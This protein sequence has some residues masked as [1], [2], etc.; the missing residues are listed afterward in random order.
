M[1][2]ETQK[3]DLVLPPGSYAYM[4]DV[5]KGNVKIY[6]G[7]TVINPTAQER[8]V[9]FD[10]QTGT[11]RPCQT[12]EEAMKISPIAA[13]GSYIVLRNPAKTH[14]MPGSA[15]QGDEQ[16]FG[17]TII[18]PGPAS[19]A[20]WPGQVAEVVPGH[21]LR[22]NQFL[23][24]R[25]SNEEEARRN[26]SKAVVKPASDDA[27]SSAGSTAG[28]NGAA[29]PLATAGQAELTVADLPAAVAIGPGVPRPTLAAEPPPDLSMGRQLIIRGTE[30]SFYIP[31]TGIEV[32]NL[33]R[34]R[35]NDS[36]TD[37]YVRDA[38]TL[39]TLEYAILV[40][41]T[42]KKRYEIGPQVVF[43][44]PTERF[45]ESPDDAGRPSKKLRA[46][47][48]NELQ[49]I[50]VKVIADYVDDD[51]K[52][53]RAGEE[54]FI[55][56]KVAQIYYPREEHAIVKYDGRAKHFATAIPAGEG[57]YLLNR[58]T[59]EI[60]TIEGPRMLLPDPRTEVIV[61][62]VLSDRECADWYPGN[63]D[64]L[65]YNR[66]LRELLK[67]APTTRQGT[68][69]E[70]E[71]TRSLALNS[72]Q[73]YAGTSTFAM[74]ASAMPASHVGREQNLGGE[75]FSRASTYTQP[76]TITL[77]TRFQGVPQI[78][79][80]TG[81]A[82]LV[83][84]K[85]GR[86]RVVRGP[87]TALLDYDEVLESM[88]LSTGKPKTTD[89]LV[90]VAYLRVDNNK[91]SDV[92]HAETSD[93]VQVEI[94]L[95]Y[96]VNFET[97]NDD[98][99]SADEARWFNVDNYVKFLCDHARSVL[100]GAVRKVT[101]EDF[102]EQSTDFVRDV[103]LGHG[104]ARDDG[105]I[106]PRPGMAFAQNGMRVTDVEVL[107]VG[108]KDEAIRQLL[109]RAHHDDIRAHVETYNL[110][111]NL[112][113]V[114]RREE[115]TREQELTIADTVR[116]RHQ[117]ETEQAASAL[118]LSLAKMEN[119]LRELTELRKTSEAESSNQ[120]FLH[121]ADLART[122]RDSDV[123]EKIARAQQDL[124]LAGLRAEVESTVARFQ[125]AQGGF[126]EA[127]LALSNNE[128]L[129]KVAQA[130][131]V[132]RAIAGES[133]A[134]ILSRMFSGTP[135]QPLLEKITAPAGA[136]GTSAGSTGNGARPP[137]RS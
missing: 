22:S 75:E 77:D 6:T 17:R 58:M 87:T 98:A 89:K 120:D 137:A 2:S 117:I 45:V 118:A 40:S 99:G 85:T 125:A 67:D 136:A 114:R 39:E 115:I 103:L 72:Q 92:I 16:D 81:Y 94:Y 105:E 51:G 3:R 34:D 38:L 32:V 27:G 74:S 127:L 4:Q 24:V 10:P 63:A 43:P 126:S 42:G 1:S 15:Q 82:A 9:A 49:G 135:M 41:E 112:E 30:V 95:S 26:W 79:V 64:A 13:E 132:Q 97:R 69:S 29:I 21:H 130:W 78:N 25:V 12:L 76:R 36:G 122:Q 60:Q 84:S 129:V 35:R 102:Y 106:G 101:I 44:L 55:T 111:R 61:R 37:R 104:A 47:E 128:T 48:L 8:P 31:P 131:D 20:L 66:G 100:K 86:R 113:I 14:P 65:A 121:D 56:G 108:V 5:T 88:E 134:Q 52:K 93:H 119:R 133:V 57:R 18:V 7:P 11:F 110:Q 68:V 83:V 53:H 71:L 50:H 90:R 80:W 33:D 109:D 23:I 19:F 124:H 54:L 70:G 123:R 116:I 28:A 91:I 107:K 59:G 73:G 46:I 96:L 62:R